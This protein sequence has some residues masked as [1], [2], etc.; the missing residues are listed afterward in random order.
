[1]SDKEFI[2]IGL[3]LL[4]VIF[5]CVV[6][7]LFYS[8]KRSSNLDSLFAATRGTPNI[9]A[10]TRK[11][12]NEA[13]DEDFEKLKEF[14]KKEYQKGKKQ[15][16]NPEDRYYHAGMLT[17]YEIKKF[18]KFK[19]ILPVVLTVVLGLLC[20]YFMG[21]QKALFGMLIGTLA[22]LAFPGFI[23]DSKIANRSEEIMYY[24][25]LVIE[26]IA[27][28]VSSSLDIGPCLQRIIQMADERDTHNVV[29]E[30]IRHAENY[31]KSGVT[32]EEALT[33]IGIKSGH[34]EL[35]HSF[36]ALGQVAKHGG[37]ITKQLHE[38]A[39]AVS[40]QRET[41]IGAKIKKLE[42]KATGPVALVF[43]GFMIT[44]FAGLMVKMKDMF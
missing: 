22:G 28:G 13:G 10:E 30:L 33:E 16:V 25:P 21:A 40:T 42:L 1:M 43:F 35:K 5:A 23:L 14:Q 29:T 20:W 34:T 7:Y 3:I 8:S 41:M 9:S 4:A 12:L 17:E 6:V 39:H 18:K 36:M 19:I 38:L 32:L 11:A 44:L 27:I 24:L 2:I 37:E 31:I 15:K 26:Q